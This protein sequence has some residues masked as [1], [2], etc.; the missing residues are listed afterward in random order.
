[1]AS[2]GIPEGLIRYSVGI[3][4][5]EDLTADLAAALEDETLSEKPDWDSSGCI[6]GRPFASC[7]RAGCGIQCRASPAAPGRS[8]DIWQRPV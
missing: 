3:E 4:D 5:C 1:M 2:L 8:S 6:R 7:I